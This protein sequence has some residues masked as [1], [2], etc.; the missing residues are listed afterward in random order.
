MK[1]AGLDRPKKN[2]IRPAKST[3]ENDSA[4]QTN[5]N[6]DGSRISTSKFRPLIHIF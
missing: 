4:C 3:Q 6:Q 1:K 5:N 2:Y